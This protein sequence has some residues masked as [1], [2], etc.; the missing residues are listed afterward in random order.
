MP[1][2]EEVPFEDATGATRKEYDRAMRRAGRIW[3]IL[4]I[5]SHNGTVMSDSM[6]LYRSIMFGDSPLS[7]AQREMIAVVTSQI[8]HCHY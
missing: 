7:R 4:S 3:N 6:R 1:Y 8:N 2:I 5:Q